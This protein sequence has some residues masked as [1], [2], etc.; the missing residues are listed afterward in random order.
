MVIPL[1]RARGTID[2]EGNEGK[3]ITE[4]ESSS[5]PGKGKE[6]MEESNPEEVLSPHQLS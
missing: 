2:L 1:N 5:C 3:R 6:I 4:G